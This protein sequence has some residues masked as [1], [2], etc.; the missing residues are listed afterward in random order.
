M[1][2]IDFAMLALLV[3]S[4]VV[5]EKWRVET[6]I[7]YMVMLKDGGIITISADEIELN[8]ELNYLLFMK[9]KKI[10]GF[11]VWS[12]IAGFYEVMYND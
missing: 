10:V 6:V 8:V 2:G 3:I 12:N 4:A 9:R 1:H 5:V 7:D 11:F